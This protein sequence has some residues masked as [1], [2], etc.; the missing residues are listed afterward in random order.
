MIE[1]EQEIKIVFDTEEYK[2]E[3]FF[4][5]LGVNFIKKG[6][7]KIIIF[8]EALNYKQNTSYL[9]V[10]DDIDM[11]FL[12][13]YICA[14]SGGNLDDPRCFFDYTNCPIDDIVREML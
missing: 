4:N 2:G 7:V 6:V 1:V 12:M 9:K 5:A 10:A 14:M 3:D 11:I 8:L 13:E